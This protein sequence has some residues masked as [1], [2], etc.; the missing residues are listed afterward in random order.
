M[1]KYARVPISIF[2]KENDLATIDAA[3]TA[4]QRTRSN[5]LVKAGLEYSKKIGGS[6]NE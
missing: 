6:E 2:V 5:F 4:D 1:E 3:A